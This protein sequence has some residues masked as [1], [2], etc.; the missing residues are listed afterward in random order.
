[1]PHLVN[2]EICGRQVSSEAAR[3]IEDRIVCPRCVAAAKKEATMHR[4]NRRKAKREARG[5]SG[6]LDSLSFGGIP[7]HWVAVGLTALGIFSL[8]FIVALS[9]T[10]RRRSTPQPTRSRRP[11]APYVPPPPPPAQERVRSAGSEI[12]IEGSRGQEWAVCKIGPDLVV[13]WA[14]WK[15]LSS[16]PVTGG[17]RPDET[18]KP[19]GVFIIVDVSIKNTGT[20]AKVCHLGNLTLKWEGATYKPVRV[21]GIKKPLSARV[22]VQPRL[23]VHAHVVYDVPAEVMKARVGLHTDTRSATLIW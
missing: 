11:T 18:L 23:T 17:G 14:P 6:I 2:C 12:K 5:G 15:R 21:I 19:S 10:G 22:I 7:G 20:V 3:P 9:R 16:Y 4:E 1:M 13:K 8:L